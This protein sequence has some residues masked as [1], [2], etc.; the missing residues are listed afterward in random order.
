VFG[1]RLLPV[2][3]NFAALPAGVAEVPLGTPLR[4][5]VSL[6]GTPADGHA[7][8]AVL[9]GGPSGGI[10]PADVLDTPYDF[11][12]LRAAGAHIGSGSVA[13]ADERAC[14]VDLGRILTRFCADE[15]CGKTIPCRIGTRRLT[16]IGDRVAMGRPRPTDLDLLADLSHDI[17]ESGLCDHERLATLPFT[18]GMRYFRSELDDHILRSSCPAG[19]CHPIAVAAAAATR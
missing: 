2:I 18:S 3:R 8:K 13:V 6:G 10:L 19:V 15:A 16:E 11:D 4:D 14:V 5:I 7:L 17:V 9:V 1:V 12:A